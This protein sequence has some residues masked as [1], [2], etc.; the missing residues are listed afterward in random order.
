[1]ARLPAFNRILPVSPIQYDGERAQVHCKEDGTIEIY[2]R[3][4]ENNTTKVSPSAGY[5]ALSSVCVVPPLSLVDNTFSSPL[6]CDRDHP[7]G[8]TRT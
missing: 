4:S 5:V 7:R 8:S 1:M 2:S 3:N 6:F